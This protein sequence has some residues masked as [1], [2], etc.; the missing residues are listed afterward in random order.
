MITG[1]K[2]LSEEE[3]HTYRNRAQTVVDEIQMREVTDLI[4]M[5]NEVIED[6]QKQYYLIVDKLDEKWVDDNLRYRLIKALIETVRDINRFD[7]IKP[8]VVLREDL[9]GHVFDITQDTGFQQEK[10]ASLYL[11]VRWTRSQLINLIDQRINLLLKSRY[12]KN[13]SITHKDILPEKIGDKATIDYILDRTLMRPRDIIEFFNTAIREATESPLITEKMI[14][15]AERSYSRERLDSIYY[16][17]YADYPNLKYWVKILRDEGRDFLVGSLD[18]GKIK[19][20]CLEYA[21]NYMHMPNIKNDRLY[22]VAQQVSEDK[23]RP[24]EFIQRLIYIFYSAG[25][26]GIQISSH[27]KPQWSYNLDK[28]IDSEDIDAKTMIYIH[29]CFRDALNIK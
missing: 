2:K 14:L 28:G 25:L 19:Q 12:S 1:K 9:L 29:P 11:N 3:K 26:V 5:L 20:L 7:N 13:T 6:Q 23:L 8:L 15:D 16:E 18:E 22:A 21:V 17:W 10:Y 4:G 27:T 24:L